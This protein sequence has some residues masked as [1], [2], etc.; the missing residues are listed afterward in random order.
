MIER[1]LQ[2]FADPDDARCLLAST[3]QRLVA[4]AE[5][6]SRS[7]DP[8][9][10]DR[11]IRSDLMSHGRCPLH[12]AAVTGVGSS[13]GWRVCESRN[14]TAFDAVAAA[15]NTNFVSFFIPESQLDKYDA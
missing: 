14:S 1:G 8:I 12:H 5:R 2:D 10:A 13:A 3:K 7:A 11:P 9:N 4:G 6:Q 15:S